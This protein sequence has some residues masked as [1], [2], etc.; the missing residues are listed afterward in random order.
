LKEADL[1]KAEWKRLL[2]LVRHDG[3]SVAVEHAIKLIKNSDNPLYY[4]RRFIEL[5][6]R[7]KQF[8]IAGKV[9]KAV[10]DIG[11]PHPII[12][13]LKGDHLW[14]LG[15]HEEAIAF[16]IKSAN[17]WLA[18]YIYYQASKFLAKKGQREKSD[19]YFEIAVA[20]AKKEEE[21]RENK[22]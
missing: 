8:E 2:D 17:Q 18:P 19:Y 7:L 15:K 16:S 22:S 3:L 10:D 20:L 21:L 5:A 1:K 11:I 14:G 9:I 13:N 6:L 4:G 12:D